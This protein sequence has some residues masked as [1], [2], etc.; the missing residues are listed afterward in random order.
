M[1]LLNPL[2]DDRHALAPLAGWPTTPR[3][4]GILAAL[5]RGWIRYRS[6]QARRETVRQLSALDRRTL[7]DLEIMPTEI[8]SLVY[9][10][11]NDRT[12]SYDRNWWRTR[13]E[14]RRG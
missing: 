12:H 1:A 7:R 5:Y 2:N 3:A 14:I 8:E 6:W 4:T 13:N 10:E 9:A 11:N